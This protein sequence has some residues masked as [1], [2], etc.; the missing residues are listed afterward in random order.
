[1][2]R[3][4]RTLM[5]CILSMLS[6]HT[7]ALQ[8]DPPAL[9]TAPDSLTPDQILEVLESIEGLQEI[10]ISTEG[11][12]VFIDGIADDADSI[13]QA[14]KLLLATLDPDQFK[15]NIELSMNIND[16]V[17]GAA[18]RVSERIDRMLGYLPLIPI[19]IAVLLVALFFAWI[20][21]KMDALFAR[22]IKNPFLQGIAQR[23]VQLGLLLIGLLIALEIMDAVALIGG[24]LG[25]AGVFG[26]AIGF[27][28]RDLVENYI[29][30]ILLSLR[31]PFRPRDH[32]VIDGYEGL[33]TSMNTRTTVL[34]TF[35]GN[36]VRI[37][38]AVVFKTTLTNYTRDPRRRFSFTVGVGYDVDLRLAIQTG[39]EVVGETDGVLQEPGPIGVITE[40]GDSSITIQLFGWVDQDTHS[41]SKVRSF[42]MQRIKSRYDEL[43]IDMPEP[44]YKIKM[45]S[46]ESTESIMDTGQSKSPISEE[47]APQSTAPEI[48]AI[49]MAQSESEEAE[50]LLDENARAE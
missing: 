36:I 19:A 40:L 31:Q 5:I 9:Q 45:D 6:T 43:D 21:G 48:T 22:F 42:A 30:S 10:R 17:S 39:I 12:F 14:D 13:E 15:N 18:G 25:A 7:L 27:A 29:A 23:A 33:V 50:N 24:V 47:E 8:P 44:I 38:N 3:L 20:V 49:E 16:R 34:T 32:V 4:T 26:L 1:M 28:F 41:F 11:E 37:P 35:D 46:G 2:T